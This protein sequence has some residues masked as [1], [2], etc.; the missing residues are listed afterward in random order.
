M[1]GCLYVRHPLFLYTKIS[2]VVVPACMKN[3][4]IKKSIDVISNFL[5]YLAKSKRLPNW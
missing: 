3:V 1:R 4:K 2:H 5:R